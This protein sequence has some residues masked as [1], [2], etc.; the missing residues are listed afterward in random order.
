MTPFRRRREG[1]RLTLGGHER[2]VLRDL[3]EQLVAVVSGGDQDDPAVARLL[4]TGYA[5]DAEAAEEFRRFTSYDLVERKLHNARLVLAAL[6][7]GAGEEPVLDDAAQQSWLR[8]LTDLRL[9][10]GARLGVTAEGFPPGDD[11][12]VLVLQDVYDWLGYV[13]ESLVRS[14]R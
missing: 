10:I 4:P 11:P 5:D 13:Q 3:V 9:T 7:P 14:L 6:D 1:L 12:Q 2:S 8:T